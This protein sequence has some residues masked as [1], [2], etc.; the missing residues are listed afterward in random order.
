MAELRRR[1]AAVKAEKAARPRILTFFRQHRWAA[2]AAA[3]FIV[4]LVAV[5]AIPHNP[6]TLQVA[7]VPTKDLLKDWP[8]DADMQRDLAKIAAGVELL[9]TTDSLASVDAA[10][11]HI[12]PA[13][14]AAVED[15]MMDDLDQLMEALQADSDT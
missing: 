6:A 11:A 13:A 14:P 8:S 7:N 1:L 4:A 2:A 5:T 12:V 10:P 3:V 15:P 9:E